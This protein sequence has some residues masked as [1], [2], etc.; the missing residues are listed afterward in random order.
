MPTIETIRRITVQ[1]QS[2]GGDAVRADLLATA[3][4]QQK[5][6]DAANAAAVVA[7]VASRRQLSAASAFDR[8][9]SSVDGSF[10]AQQ[11]LERGLNTLNRA[12]Q[13]GVVDANTYQRTF[14]MLQSKYGAAAAEARAFEQAQIAA[15]RA[16]IQAR[17]AQD[18]AARAFQGG[19]NQRLGVGSSMPGADR[20]ADPMR[21]SESKDLRDVDRAHFSVTLDAKGDRVK[22]GMS[23]K[24][25]PFKYYGA[26]GN[27]QALG[28]KEE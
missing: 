2:T 15:A 4:A 23:G 16:T 11:A 19:L 14:D 8:V 17:E 5:V 13:Q 26:T 21:E 12:L 6:G 3:A 25:L 22:I 1:Q 9:R 20:Q 28:Y 18:Q 27:E 7:E 10:K 24:F